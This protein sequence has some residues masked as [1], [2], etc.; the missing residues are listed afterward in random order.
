MRKQMKIALIF[1]F[2]IVVIVFSVLVYNGNKEKEWYGLYDPD[3][4]L[5]IYCLYVTDENDYSEYNKYVEDELSKHKMYVR[6]LYTGNIGEN[7]MN[8]ETDNI[9]YIAIIKNGK[10]KKIIGLDKIIEYN[11]N[12]YEYLDKEMNE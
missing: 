11:E 6:V 2:M 5:D 4:K 8:L 12:L 1:I 3:E 9:P 7:S 10:T